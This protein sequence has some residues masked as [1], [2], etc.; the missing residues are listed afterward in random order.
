MHGL[1]IANASKKFPV[2]FSLLERV[3]KVVHVGQAWGVIFGQSSV[4]SIDCNTK[5]A[6]ECTP[7]VASR[8]IIFE[9]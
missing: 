2:L 4:S 5:M 8:L 1:I 6:Q 9:N 7:E 3:D